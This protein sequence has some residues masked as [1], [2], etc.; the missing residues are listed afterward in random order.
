MLHLVTSNAGHRLS[1]RASRATPP[2]EDEAVRL[3]V[4]ERYDILDTPPEPAFDRITALAADLFAAPVAIIGFVGL[5]RVSLKSHHG[6]PEG[7][8]QRGPGVSSR[9]LDPWIRVRFKHGF[10]LGLPLGTKDGHELGTLSVID[11]RPRR[12][13]QQQIRHLGSLT[14]IVMDQ[15]QLRLS[16]RETAERAETKLS[17]IDDRAMNSL[18]FIASLLRLQSRGT[19]SP[20][21][22]RAL[23]AAA[24]RVVAVARVHR[25]FS[26]DERLDHV[27][28]VGYL[29]QLCGDLSGVL[30]ADIDVEGLE[31][32]VPKGQILAIGL[33][34]NELVTNA[35]RQ[36]AGRIKVA[37][38]A[39]SNGQHELRVLDEGHGPSDNRAADRCGA[40]RLDMRVVNALVTQLNGRLSVHPDPTGQSS[41]VGMTFPAA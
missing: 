1:T 7:Y 4:L 15:L 13:D 24:A 40:D 28:I 14:A 41:C 16:A 17:E 11:R 8:I 30:A 39:G 33:I 25:A 38:G 34:V 10:H 19:N 5:D 6:L 29:R 27:P 12:V 26:T 23:M 2:A 21:T 35:R 3:A 36:G 9:A 20:R 18:Q 31:E 32:N 22:S 37:F